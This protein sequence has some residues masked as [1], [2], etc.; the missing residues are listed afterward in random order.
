MKRVAITAMVC[1]SEGE[2]PTTNTHQTGTM[3]FIHFDNMIGAK[4]KRDQLTGTDYRVSDFAN[5]ENPVKTWSGTHAD[6]ILDATDL[7]I[8][9]RIEGLGGNDVL[10]GTKYDDII[11][12]GEG[13]DSVIFHGGRDYAVGG[14]G[15][16]KFIID[17]A[18][19]QAGDAITIADMSDVGDSIVFRNVDP[20]ASMTQ[21]IDGSIQVWANT[22]NG[23]RQVVASL[24]SSGQEVFALD[25]NMISVIA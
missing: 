21:G 15:K 14:N 6:E 3:A 23:G 1:A 9:Y 10:A 7:A 20:H 5:K 2:I 8:G 22:L 4:V 19:L 18:Q 25:N 16:D 12:G 24:I 17:L 13:N 11:I